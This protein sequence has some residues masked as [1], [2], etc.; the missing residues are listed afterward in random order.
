MYKRQSVTIGNRSATSD[1]YGN[2]VVT[3]VPA[4]THDVVIGETTG[5]RGRTMPG[6]TVSDQ[7]DNQINDISVETKPQFGTFLVG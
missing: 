4:G 6:I 3:K 1:E 2:F 5:T 7:R